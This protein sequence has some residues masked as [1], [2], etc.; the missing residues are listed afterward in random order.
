MNTLDSSNVDP[1]WLSIE[2]MAVGL[3]PKL[4]LLCYF[5]VLLYELTGVSSSRGGTDAPTHHIRLPHYRSSLE[6][7]DTEPVYITHRTHI[8]WPRPFPFPRRR[9]WYSRSI[10][11]SGRLEI[12]TTA[13]STHM[14]WNSSVCPGSSAGPYTRA[15]RSR[16]PPSR[17]P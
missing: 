8:I 14:L 9:I 12:I 2:P 5:I 7:E 1:L 3:A 10:L 15:G 6:L 13:L 17:I 11:S 4:H 16:E